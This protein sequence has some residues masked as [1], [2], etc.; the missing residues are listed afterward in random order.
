MGYSGGLYDL[1]ASALGLPTSRTLR[2]YTIP[3]SNDPDGMLFANILRAVDEFHNLNPN[4]GVDYIIGGS[5]VL[6]D[7]I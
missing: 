4:V 6:L 5:T 2:E 3:T 7:L 1:V